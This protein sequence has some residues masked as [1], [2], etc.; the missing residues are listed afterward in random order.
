MNTNHRIT[1]Q[2]LALLAALLLVLP[3]LG[4]KPKNTVSDSDRRKASYIFLEALN[5]KSHNR[6]DSYF[7][8][9]R[10]AHEIDPGNTAVSYHLGYCMLTM[11]NTTRERVDSAM[12]LMKQHYEAHPEDFY[13]STFYSDA[14]LMLGNPEEA[15]RWSCRCAWPRRSSARGSTSSRSRLMTPSRPCTAS[16]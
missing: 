3:A 13:E 5:E 16:R 14:N 6:E 7:D 4:G 11:Q 9:L 12:A 10:R 1:R 2:V 15:L 8:L